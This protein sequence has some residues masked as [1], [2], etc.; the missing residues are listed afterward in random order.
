M[1]FFAQRCD[2]VLP[3]HE[4]HRYRSFWAV[5]DAGVARSVAC[6]PSGLAAVVQYPARKLVRMRQLL[7]TENRRSSLLCLEQSA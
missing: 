1:S 3:L 4:V 5:A 7:T 6:S 2:S